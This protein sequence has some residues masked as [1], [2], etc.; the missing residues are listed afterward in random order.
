MFFRTKKY[1]DVFVSHF[2]V[3]RGRRALLGADVLFSTFLYFP[4]YL[5]L[6]EARCANMLRAPE[7]ETTLTHF[8][9][10]AVATL[11]REGQSR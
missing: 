5:R 6:V 7:Q 8:R 10:V 1:L 4:E 2:T 3:R 11:A 9:G